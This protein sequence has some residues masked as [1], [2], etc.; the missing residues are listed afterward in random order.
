MKTIHKLLII[1]IFSFFVNAS[2]FAQITGGTYTIGTGQTYLTFA[3]AISDIGVL[4]GDLTF[5][6]YPGTYDE[7]IDLPN[8]SNP[9]NHIVTFKKK[10]GEN[11]EV[12]VEYFAN[13]DF[14]YVIQIAGGHYVIQEIHFMNSSTDANVG[15]VVKFDNSYYTVDNNQFENCKFTGRTDLSSDYDNTNYSVIYNENTNGISNIRFIND[16][17]IGG[18]YSVYFND[19]GSPSF[20][21]GIIGCH[22]T[23]FYSEG[24]RF[25][26]SS[27]LEIKKNTIY[28]DASYVPL[29]GI[30]LQNIQN[31]FDINS[32]K[33]NLEGTS[34]NKT[35]IELSNLNTTGY[36]SLTYLIANNMLTTRNGGNIIKSTGINYTNASYINTYFNSIWIQDGD[37]TSAAVD[38]SEIHSSYNTIQNNII[39]NSGTQGFA[40]IVNNMSQNN[41]FDYNLYYTTTPNIFK[42]NMYSYTLDSWISTYNSDYNSFVAL[43]DFVSETDLHILPDIS[44]VE[45]RAAFNN[46]ITEDIDGETRDGETP[47]IG[48]DEGGFYQLWIGD[49]NGFTTWKDT[50]YINSD[51]TISNMGNLAIVPGTTVN[52]MDHYTIFSNGCINAY[53]TKDSTILFTPVDKATGWGGIEFINAQMGYI[54]NLNYCTFEYALN[55]LKNGGALRIAI[56]DVNLYHCNFNNN[57]AQYGGAIYTN[58]VQPGIFACSFSQNLAVSNGGALFSETVL[59][60]T[61]SNVFYNN[62]AE[63][64]GA[65][66]VSSIPA[67]SIIN[68]TFYNNS[69]AFSGQ[70][71]YIEYSQIGIINSIC[72]NTT[73]HND[74]IFEFESS[75]TISNCI[76]SG[77]ISATNILNYTELLGNDPLFTSPENQN[78]SLQPNSVGINGGYVGLIF[79]YFNDFA[80]NF[81]VYDSIDIGA[82][83]LQ[84]PKLVADAGEDQFICADS[85]YINISD[86]YPYFGDWNVLSGTAIIDTLSEGIV[87][88]S[89]L[90]P[91]TTELEYVVSNGIVSD[92]DTLLIINAMPF[93]YA[94]E[95]IFLIEPDININI[96]PDVQLNANAPQI[97]EW[98]YWTQITGTP[99]VFSNNTGYNTLCQNINYG[100]NLFR[101]TVS[102]ESCSNYDDMYVIAGHSF[103]SDPDD[104]VL[105]WDNPDDW[106]VT[107]VPGPADSVTIFGCNAFIQNPNAVC[108]RLIIGNGGNVTIEGTDKAVSDLSCRTVF[109]EQNAEKF[110]GIKGDVNL[111]IEN[112]ATLNIGPD[113]VSIGMSSENSGLFVLDGASVNVSE[114]PFKTVKGAATLN[115]GSGGFV[116]IQQNA[117]K[118]TKGIAEMRIGS[119]GFVFIQQNAEKNANEKTLSGD[120]NI[121]SGGFVFIEQN[122]EKTAGGNLHLTGGRT[123]FIEQNAEKNA[124]GG[125]HLGIYGG[126]VFIEQNAEKNAK[127]SSNPSIYCGRGGTIFI[128]QNAEKALGTANLIAPDLVIN[129]GKVKVGNNLKTKEATGQLQF[130]QIFI[131]QNAE[132]ALASDTALSVYPSGGLIL[133][134]SSYTGTPIITIEK[135]N[136]VTFYEG[137]AINL[138]NLTGEKAKIILKDGSSFIDFNTNS[139]LEGI[140]EKIITAN[141]TE[142]YSPILEGVYTNSFSEATIFKFWNEQSA[143]WA[144][145]SFGQYLQ[146]GIGYSVYTDLNDASYNIAGIIN[147]GTYDIPVFSANTSGSINKGINLSGNPYP[148]SINLE[149]LTLPADI[150]PVFYTYNKTNKNFEL[151]KIGG[152]SINNSDQYIL[153]G[154]GF[155]IKTDA[156][157]TFTFTNSARTHFFKESVTKASEN[158]LKLEVSGFD[159]FDQSIVSSDVNAT[160]LFDAQYDAIKLSVLDVETPQLYSVLS[161][162]TPCAINVFKTETGNKIIPL[163]FKSG[164]Y[165]EYTLNVKDLALEE[166][167]SVNLIDRL[168]TQ[169]YALTN[170]TTFNFSYT[171][172]DNPYRFDLTF[173]GAT[174]IK[175]INSEHLNIYTNKNQIFIHSP[176][177]KMSLEIYNMNGQL[178][179]N[180]E[181][182]KEGLNSFTV[183]CSDGLYI[184]KAI[185]E[186]KHFSEKIIITK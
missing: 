65:I 98:G 145:T 14:N 179:F 36:P 57:S 31:G 151:Y 66:A 20:D 180:K 185:T 39:I 88:I 81:R 83:E 27:I 67:D 71:I 45:R 21:I 111:N 9:N 160:D 50:V 170:T 105:N 109:I 102:N 75:S 112:A 87:K 110:P 51:V 60:S 3:A 53:G 90:Q 128:E 119:G 8:L 33:I 123:I 169:T 139:L 155:F 85:V 107:G 178:I 19:I 106:D 38:I 130:R 16:T 167:F 26:S 97:S 73:A 35:C 177:E 40:V 18:S 84:A 181:L 158:T 136:A 148:S 186:N 129:G 174:D 61:E 133:S 1:C 52:F 68:C 34:N 152:I 93:A 55:N 156:D 146:P 182:T 37:A 131:E 122:A 125:G 173:I 120:L 74:L 72:Y 176:Y 15:C 5:E 171:N 147:T 137:S 166:G 82:Y 22:I 149:A 17:I 25:N 116:F 132:K 49:I 77:G 70:D 59:P 150:N 91:G 76:L 134:D 103:V 114:N 11:G 162:N 96:F 117:E 89:G 157:A 183:N 56:D 43:P 184:I 100:Q 4:T 101:W 58:N 144:N 6:V 143:D 29:K 78:F 79:N 164:I 165:G 42:D 86:P 159:Y 154:E 104:G 115:I 140:S 92:S 95:D 63:N 153:P 23:N 168:T 2:V 12:S 108:D 41:S 127:T 141:Q 80:G 118:N 47:D 126:T 24:L 142:L 121:G 172:G 99:V 113:Y 135:G 28:S 94:G 7:Q 138:E 44:C 163:H 30:Y 64:G 10:E 69:A 54:S 48:A 46:L 161:D 32:N 175:D 13:S 62:N 124:S